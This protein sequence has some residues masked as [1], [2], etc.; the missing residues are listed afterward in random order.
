MK[1]IVHPALFLIMTASLFLGFY[2]N[3]WEMVRDKKFSLFQK[4]DESYVIARIV[5]TRQRGFFSYGGLLGWGDLD[6][7]P[8]DVA[9]PQ[10]QYQYDVYFS[11]GEFQEYLPKLSHP[12]FQGLFFSLLDRASPFSPVINLRLFRMLNSGL[13]ALVLMGVTLWFYQVLGFLPALL[14]FGSILFSAWMTLFGRNLFFVPWAFYLPFVVLLW[15]LEGERARRRLSDAQ[16]F[17]VTSSLMLI[18]CLLNGY[19][20]ILPTLGMVVSPILFYTILEKWNKERFIRRFLITAAG[21]GLGIL[22]S[23]LILSIQNIF[24]SG[25]LQEGLR[26]IIETLERRT[27]ASGPSVPALYEEANR[28]STWVILRTYF[29]ESYFGKFAFPYYGITAL[30]AGFSVLYLAVRKIRP[31]DAAGRSK[32]A[33]LLGVTWLSL[34]SPLSWYVIFKSVAYFH[35]HMNYLPFHMPFTLFGFG[36]CGYTLAVLAR[37]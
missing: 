33:A 32:G 17:S 7:A 24:V 37:K 21:A 20:F 22:I 3:Q 14:V 19:D 13:F 1:K 6:V 10:Y 12:G 36:L 8:A 15:S 35:T 27:L 31:E 4:G 25:S 2:R 23:L 16:F 29:S 11:G 26:V 9:E 34:L 28:A 5:M 30:F 18:K